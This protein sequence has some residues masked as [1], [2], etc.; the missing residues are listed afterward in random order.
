MT[1]AGEDDPTRIAAAL[2]Q[3][4]ARLLDELEWAYEQLAQATEFT[5]E[6]SKV[7]YAEVRETVSRLERRVA[8]LTTLNEVGRALGATLRLDQVLDVVIRRLR[9]TLPGTLYAVAVARASGMPL[10]LSGLSGEAADS[11]EGR[12]AAEVAAQWITSAG[13]TLRVP[14]A[15]TLPAGAPPALA[16]LTA[17]R[18]W[19]GVPLFAGEQVVGALVLAHSAPQAFQADDERLLDSVAIQA[20]VAVGNA[21]LYEAVVRRTAELAAVLEMSRA[22]SSAWTGT[23]PLLELLS[24]RARDLIECDSLAVFLFSEDRTELL[25]LVYFGPDEEEVMRLRIPPRVGIVG[26]VAHTGQP[27]LVNDADEDPRAAHV[28]GTPLAPESLLCAPLRARDLTLGVLAVSRVGRGRGFSREDLDFLSVVASHAAIALEN[29]RLVES[30]Q[31]AYEDLKATQDQLVA[32]ERLHALGE[33]ASGVAHDFNNILGAILGRAQLLLMRTQDESVAKG[34]GVIEQAARDGAATVKRIQDFTR[35]S[36]PVEAVS[37]DV[38]EA[39]RAAVEYS[40]PRWEQAPGGAALDVAFD[41]TATDRVLASASELREV[42]MNL[43]LNAVDASPEGGRIEV[44][45]RSDAGRVLLEVA[46]TGVGMPPEVMEKAFHPFFTTKG[47][48]GTGLGL[49]VSQAI[50]ARHHGTL[51]VQSAPGRGSTFTIALPVAP[52]DAAAAADA[53]A[54]GVPAADAPA[55]PGTILVVD[56]D[57]AVADVLADALR[58]AGHTVFLALSG[59]D[60][61]AIYAAEPIDVVFTDLGMPEMDGWALIR[62]LRARDGML[63]PVVV[64]GWGLQFSQEDERAHGLFALLPKPLPVE[65][66]VRVANAAV[67]ERRRRSAQDDGAQRAA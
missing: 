37:V 40:R 32:S 13:E 47:R 45:T 66:A 29:A 34:L 28:P 53:G 54:G 62:A 27:E 12:A 57:P 49:A 1:A 58:A 51:N 16:R 20:A 56:D 60:A 31:R 9:A 6:E 65:R 46:D 3:E 44:R 55:T 33:M 50:V 36:A 14:D 67:C 5:R 30:L 23:K 8:E 38:N 61:L 43:I 18:S 52:A 26:L 22:I 35:L 17:C 4:N 39:V 10:E 48:R 42:V 21:R 63:V 25:P 19:L 2:Q 11:A 24:H 64:S 7:A 41:L 15:R 59:R